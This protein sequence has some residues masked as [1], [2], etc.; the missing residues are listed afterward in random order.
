MKATQDA[1]SQWCLNLNTPPR[2]SLGALL[3][4]HWHLDDPAHPS[5]CVSLHVQARADAH[6]QRDDSL[7]GDS[8]ARSHAYSFAPQPAKTNDTTRCRS[9]E[10]HVYVACALIYTAYAYA[11]VY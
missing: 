3:V 11:N 9:R 10:R 7:F 5:R 4:R 2:S 1:S 8:A 6:R